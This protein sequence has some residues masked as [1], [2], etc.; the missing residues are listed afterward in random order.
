MKLIYEGD[1]PAGDKKRVLYA[2]K[3]RNELHDQL[4]DLWESHVIMRQLARTARAA[5][6]ALGKSPSSFFRR[7]KGYW[8][9]VGK[10]HRSRLDTSIFAHR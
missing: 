2:S 3:I 6:A 9:T 1:L 8:T 10:Y 5:I 4:A 7:M